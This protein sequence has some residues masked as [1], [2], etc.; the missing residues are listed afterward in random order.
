MEHLQLYILIFTRQGKRL[1]GRKVSEVTNA[2]LLI[3]ILY[4]VSYKIIEFLAFNIRNNK[5]KKK[6]KVEN[7]F[8]V[9]RNFAVLFIL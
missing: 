7:G 2:L 5:K 1:N 4:F 8:L 3:I 9:I 6:K